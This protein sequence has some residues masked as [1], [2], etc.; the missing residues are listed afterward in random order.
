MQETR[1]GLS[2]INTCL[3]CPLREPTTQWYQQLMAYWSLWK[4]GARITENKWTGRWGRRGIECQQEI[5]CYIEGF[6]S[7][8]NSVPPKVFERDLHDGQI[9]QILIKGQ[10][11]T[12]PW[13]G[14]LHISVHL[15]FH[16]SP[17]DT[18]GL[19]APC[20]VDKERKTQRGS[21]LTKVK[22]GIQ[23][24]IFPSPKLTVFPPTSVP[25]LWW[26]SDMTQL[27]K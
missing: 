19:A 12:R 13:T 17:T 10:L 6:N 25:C 20:N 27:P 24:Q 26:M 2:G 4:F 3:F 5:L 8:W 23:R 16:S 22:T 18:E 21:D 1:K 7:L 14:D 11:C 15:I 9:Q